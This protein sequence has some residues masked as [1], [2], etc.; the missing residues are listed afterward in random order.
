MR[1]ASIGRNL[2]S[3][4]SAHYCSRRGKFLCP[5]GD[6]ETAFVGPHICDAKRVGDGEPKYQNFVFT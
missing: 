6:A 1:R 4:L 5:L 2:C 3:A